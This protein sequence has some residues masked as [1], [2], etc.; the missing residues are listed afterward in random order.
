MLYRKCLCTLR[1]R[2]SFTIIISSDRHLCQSKGSRDYPELIT[3]KSTH[4]CLRRVPESCRGIKVCCEDTFKGVT[5]EMPTGSCPDS[6]LEV[7]AGETD[8][9]I[10][11][12]FA[13]SFLRQQNNN[14]YW[15]LSFKQRI[16]QQNSLPDTKESSKMSCFLTLTHQTELP[17]SPRGE[18]GEG[19]SSLQWRST[20]N[21]T[22]HTKKT[23]LSYLRH[24]RVT[25][26]R[27]FSLGQSLII[28]GCN[29]P[30]KFKACKHDWTSTTTTR[31]IHKASL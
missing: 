29:T 7:E 17:R 31:F 5:L 4:A 24:C 18:K 21:D 27:L 30:Q 8:C 15:L 12:L 13:L 10:V 22:Q 20:G 28:C 14:T 9:V 2:F 19:A 26:W 11:L 25:S 3:H 23:S 6:H 16:L 1:L